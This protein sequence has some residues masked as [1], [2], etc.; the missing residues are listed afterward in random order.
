MAENNIEELIKDVTKHAGVKGFI[1]VNSEGIPIR[2]SFEDADRQLAIQYAG[3][4][5]Q[6]AMKARSAVKE[7]DPNNDLIFLR[8]RSK[9]HE[10]LIAP[11][12]EY[13]LIVIQEPIV[14]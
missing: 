6:M 12:R 5:Q 10:I 11:E 1:I 2:H 4:L 8:L 9:K 13:L 3:L 14:Q 7:I